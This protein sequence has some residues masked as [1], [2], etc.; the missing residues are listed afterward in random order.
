[1]TCWVLVRGKKVWIFAWEACDSGKNCDSKKFQKP[2]QI[3]F[4][5]CQ[6]LNILLW[7]PRFYAVDSK[8]ENWIG[9]NW[10]GKILV[11]DLKQCEKLIHDKSK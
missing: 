6:E 10:I 5:I 11:S 8:T 4:Y 9:I 2:I 7:Q 3:F 1:M